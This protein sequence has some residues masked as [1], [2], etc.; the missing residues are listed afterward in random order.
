MTIDNQNG[1]REVFQVAHTGS[2]A[3]VGPI[4]ETARAAFRWVAKARATREIRNTVAVILITK[5]TY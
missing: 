5:I 2:N 4:H 3:P 1:M